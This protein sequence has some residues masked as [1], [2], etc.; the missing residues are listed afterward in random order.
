MSK[1]F[2]VFDIDGT[3]IRWQLYHVM[4]DKLASKGVLG[5]DA[6]Q[7]LREARMIWK[8][9]EHPESFKAYERTIIQAYEDALQHLSTENFDQMIASIIEEYKD[10]TYIYTRDLLMKCKA[11]GFFMLII[12]GSHHELIEQIGKYYG[13]DDYV[14]THYGRKDTG[15]SGEKHVGS[16]DKAAVLNKLVE[17]HKLTYEGSLGIGDSGSDISMLE[18]VE[19]P[20]AFNPDKILFDKAEGNN[21]P[22]VIERKNMVYKLTPKSGEYVLIR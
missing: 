16:Q 5:P 18:L 4:V 3:L 12:S 7:N 2:A 21:W 13:F 8:R 10:Q 9:R 15:F 22:V 14:G 11:D 20:I 17:K 1:K 19:Q 6:K